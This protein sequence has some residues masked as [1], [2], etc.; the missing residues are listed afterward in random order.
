MR[1]APRVPPS[2][3]STALRL[4]YSLRLQNGS[5]PPLVETQHVPVT[6][7]LEF[8]VWLSDPD[9]LSAARS[10]LAELIR[11]SKP[12]DSQSDLFAPELAEYE[13]DDVAMAQ[14]AAELGSPDEWAKYSSNSAP[15]TMSDLP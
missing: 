15:R 9:L 2:D 13:F 8:G 6:R 7:S 14:Y 5:T 12:I 4:T 10:F 3:P 11:H 1:T